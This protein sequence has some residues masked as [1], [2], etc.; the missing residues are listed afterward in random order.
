[1]PTMPEGREHQAKREKVARL[2]CLVA[3]LVG[4]I[5]TA[6]PIMF[7]LEPYYVPLILIGSGVAVIALSAFLYFSI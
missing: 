6:V 2:F 1:M 3:A 4:V 7:R 5:V